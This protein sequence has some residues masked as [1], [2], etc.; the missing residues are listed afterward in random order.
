MNGKK[1]IKEILLGYKKTA[2]VE[3]EFEITLL[4][5]LRGSEKVVKLSLS[6]RCPFCGMTGHK[7]AKKSSPCRICNGKNRNCFSCKGS[8]KEMKEEDKCPVCYGLCLDMVEIPFTLTISKG[9]ALNPI[10][11]YEMGNEIEDKNVHRGD[12]IFTPKLKEE[13]FERR[14]D[15]LFITKEIKVMD[16]VRGGKVDIPGIDGI[17]EI[18]VEPMRDPGNPYVIQGEGLPNKENPTKRGNLY[19]NWKVKWEL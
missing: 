4:E 19:V 17:I 9:Y 15:D 16:V 12:V 7:D 3:I 13:T 8:G 14:G 18:D 6:R 5:I 2:D 10:V 11:F 1:L